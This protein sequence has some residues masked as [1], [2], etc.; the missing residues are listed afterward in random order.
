[1][2]K[3]KQCKLCGDIPAIHEITL[4]FSVEWDIVCETCGIEVTKE[5]KDGAI[6]IWNKLHNDAINKT[7]FKASTNDV[8]IITRQVPLKNGRYLE[9]KEK[10]IKDREILDAKT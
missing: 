5:N 8:V 1:M 10:L 2:A 4:T 6:R 9:L 3:P 7:E